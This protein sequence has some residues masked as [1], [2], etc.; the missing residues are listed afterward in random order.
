[1]LTIVIWSWDFEDNADDDGVDDDVSISMMMMI[2]GSAWAAVWLCRRQTR[3]HRPAEAA[4]LTHYSGGRD[5]ATIGRY[6]SVLAILYISVVQHTFG[7]HW[8]I[9]VKIAR[10]IR[11]SNLIAMINSLATVQQWQLL[12]FHSCHLLWMNPTWY[13][14]AFRDVFFCP[15]KTPLMNATDCRSFF[16]EPRRVKWHYDW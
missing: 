14:T 4:I 12:R 11:C 8:H 3:S 6:N 10:I 2:G 5:D 13:A 15:N 7:Q 1:M 16:C 9:S